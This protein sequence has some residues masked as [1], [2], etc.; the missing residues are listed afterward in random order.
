M[1]GEWNNVERIKVEETDSDGDRNEVYKVDAKASD[2]DQSRA[3]SM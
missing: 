2:I 1:I 3:N